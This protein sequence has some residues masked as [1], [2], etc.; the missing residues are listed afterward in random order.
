MGQL[1]RSGLDD[2]P[3]QRFQIVLVF[4]K[5][6]GQRRQQRRVCRRVSQAEIIDRVDQPSAKEV[7]PHPVHR[8]FSEVGMRSHPF[9]ESH[10]GVCKLVPRQR[11]A[12]QEARLH[13]L[14][15][16][17]V[18]HPKPL[19]PF[20]VPTWIIDQDEIDLVP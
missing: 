19:A 12:V 7:A 14:L 17:R 11:R 5:V 13:F 16:A 20:P 18:N 15:G 2:P 10:P 9:R 4:P 6:P 3:D 8:G 1:V